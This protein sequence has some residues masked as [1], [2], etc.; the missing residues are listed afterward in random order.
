MAWN[1]ENKLSSLGELMKSSSKPTYELG[2]PSAKYRSKS[3]IDS[4]DI[5]KS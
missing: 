5:P 2:F 1:E 3:I 4:A